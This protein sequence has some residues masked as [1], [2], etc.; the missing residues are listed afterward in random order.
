MAGFEHGQTGESLSR[1]ELEAALQAE[2]GRLRLLSAH[3]SGIIFEFNARGQF[4]RVWA[5]DP[6]LLAK[7]ESELL[8]RTVS[9]ALGPELGAFHDAAIQR[10]LL[11][12]NGDEYEYVLEVPN[13]RRCFLATSVVIP[14]HNDEERT[15]VYRIRDIT[16]RAQAKARELHNERL[17]TIGRLAAGVAHEINNP[18]AYISL[19]LEGI[20]RRVSSL[21]GR[22][23]SGTEDDFEEMASSLAMIRE[24]T[25]R[26]QKIV[27]D[28]LNFSRPDDAQTCVDVLRV[29]CLASELV[30]TEGD[31][32]VKLQRDLAPTPFVL[33]DEGRLIQVFVNLLQNAVQAIEQQQAG[34]SSPAGEVHLSSFTDRRGWAVVEV[35][36]TGCGIPDK[37]LNRIFEPFF[38]T[39][40]YGVGLGLVLC[41]T[42]V[43][44]F[45][46]QL[47]V[48]SKPGQG[49]TFRVSLPPYA[50]LG[51]EG[52]AL[53]NR[54]TNGDT[55]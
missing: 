44:S 36:D 30:L 35:R 17:A 28:L 53:G 25:K 7:P 19:N 18:L 33:A 12:G 48:F 45:S 40:P 41:Q 50:P 51:G 26:V 49:S 42:L 11:T 34:S 23:T 22:P 46:G 43:L 6:T 24:G 14:A 5:S 21:R 47:E 4:V 20:E 2:R 37:L 39:K 15:V 52:E 31:A 29:I 54:G 38:T 55:T 8:G 1:A 16:D 9:E 13:G 32:H 3:T 27:R 10:A